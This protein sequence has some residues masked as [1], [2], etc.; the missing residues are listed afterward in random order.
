MDTT[1]LPNNESDNSDDGSVYSEGLN[2][3]NDYVVRITPHGKFTLDQL[4]QFLEEEQFIC[5]YVV[6]QELVPQEH[7]HVVLSTDISIPEIEVR[8]MIKAFIVPFW[9]LPTGKC[10]KGFG[11]KQY[12]L[13]LATDWDKAV[14][15]ALKEATH[16]FFAGV[17]QSEIDRLREAS[18][19]KKS[20]KN[21]KT[22]YQ[23]LCSKFKESNMDI[24]DFMIEFTQLKSRYGQMVVIAHA[25][26]YAISN[27]I[28]RDPSAA[29]DLVENYLYKV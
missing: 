4:H 12:N 20:I 9:Q 3:T 28:A 23:E 22:E 5:R 27:L 29:E 2:P 21:F 18:Y 10:P 17:D 16:S 19:P 15:Y 8:D 11:N 25:Y 13:Q 24:R 7:F 1:P 14:S 26:N 6:G